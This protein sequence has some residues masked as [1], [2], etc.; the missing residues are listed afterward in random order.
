MRKV[1]DGHHN[2]SD[3]LRTA[4]AMIVRVSYIQ[5]SPPWCL[6]A[7]S[8]QSFQQG[9]NDRDAQNP[10]VEKLRE[11]LQLINASRFAH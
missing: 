6:S 2:E 9:T 11:V 8:F 3:N 5:I 10:L 4:N 1:R 7:P